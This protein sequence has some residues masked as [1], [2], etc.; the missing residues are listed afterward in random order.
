M[1]MLQQALNSYVSVG[2]TGFNLS[3]SDPDTV[4][5]DA[6]IAAHCVDECLGPQLES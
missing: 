4:T 5:K 1:D 2:Q 6:G 3:I